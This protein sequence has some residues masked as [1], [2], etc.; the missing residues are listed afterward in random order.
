MLRRVLADIDAAIRHDPAARTRLEVFLAYPG[1]HALWLHQIAHALWQADRRLVA[2]VVA[3]QNRFLTGVEIHP[4]ATLGAGVFIDHGMGVVIGETATVGDGCILYKGVVLGGTSLERTVRH[5]QVGKN[6]VVGSNACVLG[7]IHIG[8]GARVGSG[9]VVIK[10]V[11]AGATVVGVPGR[12]VR[13]RHREDAAASLDHG[14]L[15]DPV[16]E[17]LRTLAERNEELTQR[18]E[19]LEAALKLPRRARPRPR[20]E[21]RSDLLD[22]D[23]RQ[24]LAE[25]LT[26]DLPRIARR[27]G[28]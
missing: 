1:V 28:S 3:H 4:G 7:A 9:S 17:V 5:P 26:P 23:P 24:T 6:V 13:D 10:D 22:D 11:P 19:R 8:D 16:A 18:L 27:R 15:P 2:R 25:E 12:I 14:S 20:P 21:V